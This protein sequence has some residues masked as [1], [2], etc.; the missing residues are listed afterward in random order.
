EEDEEDDLAET[1]SEY[2]E[3]DEDEEGSVEA[4]YDDD[5]EDEAVDQRP[6]TYGPVPPPPPPPPTGEL[7]QG[8]NGKVRQPSQPVN[9]VKY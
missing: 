9:G 5:T 4:E 6:R 3:Y 1:D 8:V 2:D 7:T